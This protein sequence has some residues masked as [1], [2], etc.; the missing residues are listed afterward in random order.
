MPDL[1]GGGDKH[2]ALSF[3]QTMAPPL[4]ASI[5]AER[6]FL[7]RCY[8]KAELA[9]AFDPRAGCRPTV[10]EQHPRK[11]QLMKPTPQHLAN[12]VPNALKPT[13]K[14]LR[15][16]RLLA[17]RTGTSF[18]YPA[19][20]TDASAEITRLTKLPATGRGQRTRERRAIQRDLAER[21][22]DATPVRVGRDIRGYGSSARWAHTPD[23]QP[24][25]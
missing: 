16:L 6:A 24:R 1:I 3:A 17:D 2:Q 12:P 5:D 18:A 13:P 21:P 7:L 22:D 9:R 14:Q 19:T 20:I 23:T 10:L 25:S 8:W 4:L 15:Y 11:A